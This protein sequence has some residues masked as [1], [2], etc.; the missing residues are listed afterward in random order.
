[1]INRFTL[2]RQRHLLNNLPHKVDQ[3][4]YPNIY[5]VLD[6][7]LRDENLN[8]QLMLDLLECMRNMM[9]NASDLFRNSLSATGRRIDESIEMLRTRPP[10]RILEIHQLLI[11]ELIKQFTD[12]LRPEHIRDC[13]SPVFDVGDQTETSETT[14]T[15]ELSELSDTPSLSESVS[16]LRGARARRSSEQSRVTS[17]PR[18][19]SASRPRS[20]DE[21]NVFQWPQCELCHEEP[22]T[23]AIYRCGHVS[24]SS[25]LGK[26]LGKIPKSNDC[27]WCR[28]PISDFIKLYAP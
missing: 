22:V 15:T 20:S 19:A 26:F 10:I 27:P 11:S 24:G 6:R 21:S 16:T 13:I 4:V 7:F 14:N 1:M 2:T 3:R 25:C 18:P 8:P 12:N 17:L 9:S 23:H 28:Q 5:R